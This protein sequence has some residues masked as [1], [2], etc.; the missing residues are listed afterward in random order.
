MNVNTKLYK[1]PVP[2]KWLTYRSNEKSYLMRYYTEIYKW[3]PVVD[4]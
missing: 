1:S 3:M 2:D 4:F